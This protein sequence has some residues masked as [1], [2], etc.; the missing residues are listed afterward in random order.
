MY[1]LSITFI[2]VKKRNAYISLNR[3]DPT[4]IVVAAHALYVAVVLL[5]PLLQPLQELLV[6]PALVHAPVKE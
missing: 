1:K 6:L 4:L 2:F 3:I 5:D